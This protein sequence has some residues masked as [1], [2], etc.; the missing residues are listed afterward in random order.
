[1]ILWKSTKTNI[2]QTGTKCTMH[3]CCID[4]I[5]ARLTLINLNWLIFVRV[6]TSWLFL[7]NLWLKLRETTNHPQA[8]KKLE[9][10]IADI[11]SWA[12]QNKLMLNDSKT[13]ILHFHSNFRTHSPFP[14]INIGGSDIS[15]SCSAKD[16]G[17]LLDDTLLL[18]DHVRNICRKASFG[19]YKIGR[20][21]KYLD[22]QSTE[23]L[24]HAFVSS[25]LDCNNSLLYGLPDNL[26]SSLQRIQ[27]S[28]ARLITCTKRYDHISPTL[29]ELHWLPVV[30]R[31][32]FKILLLTFKAINGLAPNYISNLISV[33]NNKSLRSANQLALNRGP[34]VKTSNYGD[35]AFAVAAPLLWNRIPVTIR[36]AGSIEQFK[37]KL[38]TFLFK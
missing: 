28:A 26:L 2:F 14:A 34:R 31:I 25:H 27:N 24:V 4:G 11:R 29:D 10:C 33:S 35:R 23:R 30:K 15:A 7:L 1:M 13:E 18:K 36:S 17:V 32:H 38:K 16:L 12:I 19:I 6:E 37:S 3:I 20:I 21:R 22:R 9:S 5:H 8:V